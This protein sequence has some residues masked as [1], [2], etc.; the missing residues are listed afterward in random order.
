MPAIKEL[1]QF[2]QEMT[3]WRRD[4]HANP[5]LGFTDTRTG[6]IERPLLAA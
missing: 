3:G 1:E 6:T 2:Q 4:I 5:E